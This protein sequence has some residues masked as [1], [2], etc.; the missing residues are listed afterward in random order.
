MKYRILFAIVCSFTAFSLKAPDAFAW[1][2]MGHDLS[3]RV[4]SQIVTGTTKK[5]F[6]KAH[7]FDLGYYANVPDLVW[8]KPAP[9]D[10]EWTNHIMDLEIF[11]REIKKAVEES[12][13]PAKEDPYDLSRAAFEAK[14]PS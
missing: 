8:K 9:Y 5:S 1:G 4:A 14:F 2:R 3:A 10:V 13:F 11:D 7:M 12:R 6:Y